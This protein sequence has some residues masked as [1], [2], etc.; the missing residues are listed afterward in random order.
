MSSLKPHISRLPPMPCFEGKDL[1][2]RKLAVEKVSHAVCS[3]YFGDGDIEAPEG[4]DRLT[5]EGITSFIIRV[6]CS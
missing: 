6:Y 4:R 5:Q 2:E 3:A 1:Q